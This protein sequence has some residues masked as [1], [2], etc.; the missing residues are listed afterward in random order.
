M[1]KLA[2]QREI[3]A[4]QGVARIGLTG[5]SQTFLRD[6]GST[7][8]VR[9]KQ[10]VEGFSNAILRDSRIFHITDSSWIDK[11]QAQGGLEL[12]YHS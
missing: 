10:A 4:P 1:E 8:S 2:Q 9:V 6:Y 12:R 7:S 3:R 5:V 11:Y